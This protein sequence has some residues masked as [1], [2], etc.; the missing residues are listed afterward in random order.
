MSTQSFTVT[1]TEA[2][3]LISA[4][5]GDVALLFL[6]KKANPDASAED[7]AA[8]LCRTMSEISAAEE[9]L[10]RML[11]INAAVPSSSDPSDRPQSKAVP[12]VEPEY[13]E[14]RIPM[15]SRVEVVSRASGDTTFKALIDEAQRVTGKL[16]SE[17]YMRI[18]FGIYD[19]LAIPAD[20]IMLLLNFCAEKNSVKNGGSG[21]V[22]SSL[23]EREA[24]YWY[25]NGIMTHELAE[26]YA[27]KC[28]AKWT[29]T[30]RIKE[31]L[32]ISSRS[33]T[34][35]EQ[36][37][38]DSWLDMGFSLDAISIAYD[39]TVVNT[40]SLKWK[41]M[42]SILKSWHEKKLHTAAEIN[43]AE[44]QHRQSAPSRSRNDSDVDLDKL[45]SLYDRI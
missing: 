41:Y 18:L 31:A 16:L 37:Y 23:L 17:N 40:G 15:Y 44:P 30:G 28:R 19:H 27:E 6:F 10:R 33:L 13:T 36:S 26:E 34:V 35:T 5:D 11:P 38:I 39:R 9:K 12:A 14:D 42:N 3:K 25:N 2:Q 22:S 24:Y 4:H 45:K 29:G 20:V 7:A 21:K 32:G 8:A 43:A 1:D